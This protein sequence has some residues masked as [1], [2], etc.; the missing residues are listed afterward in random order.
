M[1]SEID[2]C[3][4]AKR[5]H[6]DILELIYNS[7]FQSEGQSYLPNYSWLNF[8]MFSFAHPISCGF[9]FCSNFQFVPLCVCSIYQATDTALQ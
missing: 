6:L 9:Y 2:S 1:E 5:F 8:P 7:I 3:S 4:H